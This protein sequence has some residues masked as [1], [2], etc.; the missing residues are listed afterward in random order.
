MVQT[1]NREFILRNVLSRIKDDYD[2]ILIDCSPSLGLL[3]LNALAASDSVLIPVQCEYYAL[4]GLGK[5]LNTIKII[6]NH[7][8]PN[9]DIEGFVMT[10]YDSRLKLSEQI[11]DEVR[12][13]FDKMVYNTIIFRSVKLS[14]APS[15]GQ[16]ILDY[17]ASSKGSE[18]YLAL[19]N[20]FLKNQIRFQKK[21]ETDT[22]DESVNNDLKNNK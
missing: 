6:Q 21:S 14:E 7:L 16:T 22:A 10:M 2:Y 20:E 11:V 12:K 1:P 13:H 5:L 17:D 9:L 8:N 15:F 19:A 18:N 4:E 3:V